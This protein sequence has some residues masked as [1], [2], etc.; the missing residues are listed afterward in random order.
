MIS[1]EENTKK[2]QNLSE[3]LL[4]IG[5]SL[6]HCWVRKTI[7]GTWRTNYKSWILEWLF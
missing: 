5:G 7:K 2:L 4:E 1:L 6:W 3:R